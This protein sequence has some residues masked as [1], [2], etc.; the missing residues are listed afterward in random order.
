MS[1]KRIFPL[2]I[3]HQAAPSWYAKFVGFKISM[4]SVIVSWIMS[5]CSLLPLAYTLQARNDVIIE[6]ICAASLTRLDAISLSASGFIFPAVLT[7]FLSVALMLTRNHDKE[8][9]AMKDVQFKQ[10]HKASCIAYNSLLAIKKNTSESTSNI[11]HSQRNHSLLD[12]LCCCQP[13]VTF[14]TGTKS[15][16]NS[17]L[18]VNV[19]CIV[20]WAPFFVAYL[21]IPFCYDMCIDPTMWSIFIWVGYT[22]SG[23]APMLWFIDEGVRCAALR[24]IRVLTRRRQVSTCNIEIIE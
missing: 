14:C 10:N 1:F 3:F 11:I 19:C 5:T 12:H 9:E 23:V 2:F 4:V 24:L 16:I 17:L 8:S 6:E 22:T 18:A 20:T 13:R 7:A 21:L 15:G